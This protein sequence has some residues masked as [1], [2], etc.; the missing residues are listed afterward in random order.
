MNIFVSRADLTSGQKDR[1][2]LK[3]ELPVSP[4]QIQLDGKAKQE[5]KNEM[6]IT[7]LQTVSPFSVLCPEKSFSRQGQT[8]AVLQH[9]PPLREGQE[10]KEKRKRKKNGFPTMFSSPQGPLSLVVWPEIR[11]VLWGLLQPDLRGKSH[12]K[13]KLPGN[14]SVWIA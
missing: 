13:G 2:L 10:G 14:T 12:E 8:V 1:I 11:W 5:E 3:F 6:V 7:L 4:L 9:L